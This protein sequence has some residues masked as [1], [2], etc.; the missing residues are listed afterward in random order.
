MKAMIYK[1]YGPPDVL[2]LEE[3]DKPTIEDN[4]VLIKVH[5]RT[6]S[7]G[8]ARMRQGSRK[9][10][11]MWPI[12]KL[13]IGFTKPKK[14]IL[15]MDLAGEVVSIGSK[16]T[17]FNIG[18]QVYGF[19]GKGTYVEYISIAEDGA[20]GIKPSNMN[21]EEAAAVPFGAV[22]ALYFLRK[23][24]IKSGQKILI[25][26]ASGSVGTFAIQLGKVFGAEVTGVCSTGNVEMV[27]SLGAD[28]VI[29][30]TTEDFT[31]N[32]DTYDIIFDTVGKTK[33]SQC[34][35]SLKQNGFY[36]LAVIHYPQVFQ[37]MRTSIVGDKKVVSGIAPGNTEDLVFLKKLIEEEKLVSVID[38]C[39]PLEQI[40]EAH[41]YVDKGHKKG[42]VVIT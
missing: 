32:I 8:D 25:Y 21:Y 11:P 38:R 27:R 14:N 41:E 6:V 34:K 12:S 29:D 31:Q 16:V 20:I 17:R 23:G 37:M 13:A 4:E 7:S 1:R 10:L 28:K 42:N 35:R 3:L 22:S 2:R 15:G 19:S 36:V 33:F 30:Y 9:S 40:T 24:N 39:Y 26:G 5:A 18:D